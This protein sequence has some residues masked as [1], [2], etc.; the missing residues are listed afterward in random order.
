MESGKAGMDFQPLRSIQ[1]RMPV[2]D[3]CRVRDRA[4]IMSRHIFA[5]RGE[6]FADAQVRYSWCST[7]QL[8]NF[9]FLLF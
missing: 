7:Q 9:S 6:A 5:A 4:T 8:S 2:E 1:G 3:Q